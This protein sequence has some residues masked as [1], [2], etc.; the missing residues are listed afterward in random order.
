MLAGGSFLTLFDTDY[1]ARQ[2][3][4]KNVANPVKLAAFTPDASF[5]ASTGW[6]DR[7]VKIWRRSFLGEDEER[8]DVSYLS[9]PSSVTSI[10]WHRRP[11]QDYHSDTVLY[12]TCGDS[13]LRIWAATDH[14]GLQPLQLWSQ[15]DL[16][17]AIIPRTPCLP[18]ER[19]R[20]YVFIMDG[21]EFESTVEHA[22][23]RDAGTDRES[24]TREHLMDVAYRNPDVCV[25]MDDRGNMSA[26]GLE[27]VGCK[28][29]QPNDI[30]NIAIVEDLE[31]E[32]PAA[33][34]SEEDYACLYDFGGYEDGTIN[35]LIN[36]FDGRV[37]WLKAAVDR[38]FDSAPTSSRFSVE[39]I[40]T[41][42]SDVIVNLAGN[43]QIVVSQSS[44]GDVTTW[45][46]DANLSTVLRR[47]SSKNMSKVVYAT[48]VSAGSD[49]VAFL[50]EDSVSLWDAR[51]W[52]QMHSASCGHCDESSPRLLYFVQQANEEFL[53]IISAVESS[54]WHVRSRGVTQGQDSIRSVELPDDLDMKQQITAGRVAVAS[55]GCEQPRIC[56][57][58]KD[59]VLN[60]VGLDAAQA[61]LTQEHGCRTFFRSASALHGGSNRHVVFVREDETAFQI[62]NLNHLHQEFGV[63]FASHQTITAIA[64]D[65]TASS[66]SILAVA[67]SHKVFVYT[68]RQSSFTPEDSHVW[69]PLRTVDLGEA[70]TLPIVACRWLV[71]NNFLVAAGNQLFVFDDTVQLPQDVKASLHVPAGKKLE[72]S[73]LHAAVALN[74]YLPTFG[75]E[76]LR[77]YL[78]AG[79]AADVDKVLLT[80]HQKLKY[81]TEGEALSSLLGLE[82]EEDAPE[83]NGVC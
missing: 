16:N 76:S 34:G 46:Q 37:Q 73:L 66:H 42:H 32:W 44:G 31:I 60:I 35:V 36:C 5:I 11:N 77:Q 62:W 82:E 7:L 65:T 69:T 45:A 58:T 71:G 74:T 4:T 20:R 56:V 26:W 79:C 72:A 53:I 80:L 22:L 70:T 49:L 10:R 61:Q 25:I 8:F 81:W 14:H 12:T 40:W 28:A 63:N 48:C 54:I 6:Y 9:H 64:F 29:R 1:P 27:R 51:T 55:L 43:G 75:A 67:L 17:S 78:L 2:A 24:H 41:G 59:G 39:A 15:L 33:D 47:M 38:L 68:Q 3:W 30:F 50:H 21:W 23:K 19:L 57:M 13:I 83:A 18:S 52:K